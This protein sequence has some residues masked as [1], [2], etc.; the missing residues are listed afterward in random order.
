MKFFLILFILI[1]NFNNLIN[2]KNKIHKKTVLIR[3]LK[4][5]YADKNISNLL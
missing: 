5:L 1:Y 4:F 2:Y 3:L